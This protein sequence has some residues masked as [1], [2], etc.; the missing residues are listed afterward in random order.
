MYHPLLSWKYSRYT[1]PLLIAFASWLREDGWSDAIAR[2]IV[3]QVPITRNFILTLKECAKFTG[4]NTTVIGPTHTQ[5]IM[6]NICLVRFRFR[7]HRWL[8]HRWYRWNRRKSLLPRPFDEPG[9]P[10]LYDAQPLSEE[11][12]M[13]T[14]TYVPVWVDESGGLLWWWI[15]TKR[16]VCSF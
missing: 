12:V 6:E 4:E 16:S 8:L 13:K 1:K 15:M 9:L 10:W 5:A 11:L 14:Q 3:A 7:D 2:S